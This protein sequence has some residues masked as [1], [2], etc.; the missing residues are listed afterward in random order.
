MKPE[1]Y[2]TVK[3]SDREAEV[4]RIPTS[5]ILQEEE[6]LYVLVELGNN[7]YRK[8]KIETGHT[9]DGKTVVLSGLNV[10]DEIVVT[11]AFYLLDAR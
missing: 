9:E 4:I 8:Q 5:A 2:G 10:G 7:D 3:L 1:M 6:N 11:G